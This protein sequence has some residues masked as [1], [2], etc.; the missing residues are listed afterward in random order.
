MDRLLKLACNVR[1]AFLGGVYG[2]TRGLS[3]E[4]R[5]DPGFNRRR[6]NRYQRHA[7]TLRL[8]YLIDRRFER[9]SEKI[10][11]QFANRNT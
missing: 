4:E 7:L 10:N 9:M 6:I 11:S 3:G 5:Y 1:R 8:S 2:N